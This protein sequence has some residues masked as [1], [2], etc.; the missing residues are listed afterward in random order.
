MTIHDSKYVTERVD[1]SRQQV[2][3][4]KKKRLMWRLDHVYDH[5]LISQYLERF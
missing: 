5:S 1:K 2:S 3:T 4:G